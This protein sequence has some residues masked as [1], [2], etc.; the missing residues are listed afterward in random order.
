[1]RKSDGALDDV[2]NGGRDK[3]QP[4]VVPPVGEHS[5]GYVFTADIVLIE[6]CKQ[7]EPDDSRGDVDG[8]K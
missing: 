8:D 3:P 2:N 7:K 5:R 1:M 4:V 6:E